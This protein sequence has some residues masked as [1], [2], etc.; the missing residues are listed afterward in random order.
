MHLM[1]KPTVLITNDD[2]YFSPALAAL[3]EAAEKE[4]EVVVSVPDRNR[5]AVGRSVS[6]EM[7]IR[8]RPVSKNVFA[9]SGTPVDCVCY[10]L[11]ILLKEPPVLVLSGIN[12]GANLGTDVLS[13]G[14]VAGAIE[15][16]M[17]GIP[18]IAIS[19]EDKGDY[20]ASA[21]LAVDLGKKLIENKALTGNAVVLNVN[22]PN[23]HFS[24][25]RFTKLGEREYDYEVVHRVDPRGKGYFWIGGGSIKKVPVEGSD[26]NALID[27]VASITPIQLDMTDYDEL[28]L[29]VLE[30]E[31]GFF[32]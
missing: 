10:A 1:M 14:T 11:G 16:Y 19:Q 29:W 15:G 3:I 22:T 31:L 12:I 24:Q 2:G 8:V 6:L 9:T 21:E 25:A 23:D 32:D 30:K 20:K 18:A 13:S 17:R 4:W 26:C 28:S 7:P 5:S 27:G